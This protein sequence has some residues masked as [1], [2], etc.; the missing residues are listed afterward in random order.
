MRKLITIM[1]IV[2]GTSAFGF[3]ATET[4]SNL[5]HPSRHYFDE[6]TYIEM[7]RPWMGDNYVFYGNGFWCRK[8]WGCWQTKIEYVEDLENK[9]LKDVFDGYRKHLVNPGNQYKSDS[10]YLQYVR[11]EV[12]VTF[13]YLQ[14]DNDYWNHTKHTFYYRSEAEAKECVEHLLDN[15]ENHHAVGF[16][17]WGNMLPYDHPIDT[18]GANNWCLKKSANWGRVR[19]RFDPHITYE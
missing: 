19:E 3:Y 9:S 7:R 8:F 1:A 11:G 16:D 17:L 12:K 18:N 5:L 13:D 14:R 2:V 10:A 4:E 15:S 6:G